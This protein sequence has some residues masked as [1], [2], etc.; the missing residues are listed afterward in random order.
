VRK[1]AGVRAHTAN[2]RNRD[3]HLRM[4]EEHPGDLRGRPQRCRGGLRRTERSCRS[5]RR[6]LGKLL[7]MDGTVSTQAIGMKAIPSR[8]RRLGLRRRLIRLYPVF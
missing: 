5:A 8:A 6:V 3:A 4:R 2:E 1:A 7:H